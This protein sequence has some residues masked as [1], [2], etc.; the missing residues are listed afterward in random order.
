MLNILKALSYI[1]G[2]IL[3][4]AIMIFGYKTIIQMYTIVESVEE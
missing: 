2:G 4:G 3:V 1:L